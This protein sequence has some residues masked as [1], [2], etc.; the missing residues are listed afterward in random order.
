MQEDMK[1]FGDLA[2]LWPV[3]SPKDDYVEVSEFIARAIQEHSRNRARTLLHMGCGGG[4]HDYTLKK[5]FEL[6][7]VDMSPEML[8]LARDLN[9]EAAYIEGDMR[10][11]RLGRQFDA[12]I[13]LDSIGYMLSEAALR[14]AL[15]NACEHLKPGGVFL[16]FVEMNPATF[17]QNT[18]NAWTNSRGEVELTFVENYYDPDPTDSTCECTFVYLIRE[19]GKLRIE[20]DRHLVGM[21]PIETWRGS[22]KSVGFEIAELEFTTQGR[23][24]SQAAPAIS[25]CSTTR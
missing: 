4:H 17:V 10:D 19:S 1:M 7:G 23:A 3:L 15:T 12:V 21:F 13:I 8:G 6:T 5:H 20:T 24:S 9:P 2:W 14:E 18:T 25:R 22:F 11:V 16:T